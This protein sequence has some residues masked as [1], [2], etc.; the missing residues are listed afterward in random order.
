M[1]QTKVSALSELTSPD[2]AEELLINDGGTSKK[3]TIDN[4]FNQD[5]DVTGTVTTD[6]ADLNGA[7]TI[8]DT[9]AD[10]DFRVESSTNANALVVDGLYGVGIGIG[11]ISSG[12]HLAV[13]GSSTTTYNTTLTH[14]TGDDCALAI[15]NTSDTANNFSGINF[16]DAGGF[17]NSGIFNVNEDHDA[18]GGG[19]LAFLT[20]KDS[21]EADTMTER[22]RIN[23]A[24]NVGIGTG[25]IANESD[26]KKLVISGASGTGA[27]I[28]EFADISN[29][30]DGAIFA[31]GGNLFIVADRDGA[32]ADSSI[33][34][35]VDGSSEKMRIDSSGNVG[36][37]T[38]PSYRLHVETS[39]DG[40]FASL[41]HNTDADNGQGL[42]IRAGADSGEAILS[43]RN[44]ASSTKMIVRADGNVGIGDTDPSEAKLSIDNVAS[45]DIGIKLINAQDTQSLYINSESTSQ[46]AIETYSKYGIICNVDIT[47]GQAGLFT[48]NLAEAGS[49]PLVY[50]RDDHASNTQPALSIKQDGAGYGLYIDQNGDKEG[51]YIDSE[52]TTKNTIW[53]YGKY[54]IQC[55]QDQSG[56]YA[57]YFTRNIDEAGSNPLVTITDDH[58]SNTQPALKIQQ[59]G[60][61]YG[62]SIDQNGDNI[63]LFIDSE[64]TSE[65]GIRV[66]GK[67]A[68][69]VRQD[70]SNGW[71]AE[72]QRNIDEAGT[73]PL[74]TI[75]DDHTSNTAQALKIQ[76]DGAGMG[77]HIDQNG[78]DRALYIDSE[79][80][81]AFA[82]KVHGK[83]SIQC[84]Q[85]LS[86]GYAA[87]FTRNLAEAGSEPLVQIIDDHTSNTQTALKIQQDGAGIGIEIDQNGN[88]KAL[89]IDTE[90]TT[91]WGML[92]S[93]DALTTGNAG[94]FYSNSADTSTRN[95]VRIRNDNA[96]ATGTTTL[97][98]D[99]DSTGLAADFSG[100]GGIRSAGGILFG[101]DTAA[102]NA[103]DDYEEGTWTPRWYGT[104]S[105]ASTGNPPNS[106]GKYTKIGNVVFIS[107]FTQNIVDNESPAIVG[108]VRIDG[109]PFTTASAAKSD[110]ILSVYLLYVSSTSGWIAQTQNNSDDI[111]IFDAES[112]FTEL[113]IGDLGTFSDGTITGYYFTD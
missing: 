95:L 77:L 85:D 69:N 20:R 31:D 38:T 4:I 59:D 68:L 104:T 28:I 57:G 52:S 103:L 43:L 30:I 18:N 99:Q 112:D 32:T 10:V 65:Y 67:Y 25:T 35:R 40:D 24:G 17:A 63:G 62:I 98:V 101:T 90:T 108:D 64:S 53:T 82:V 78:D 113:A 55:V 33:R 109:L 11:A 41:I 26:H 107:L 83:Y 5:I 56:G 92:V 13:G 45:G 48:R 61:G 47:G 44:Q 8:N 9:G 21:T 22:M 87:N 58:T 79:S 66:Q 89:L 36:I 100:T 93:A 2:G 3:I 102:A 97:M 94:Y 106:L 39:I 91:S 27:G 60:A 84:I 12:E 49:N 50:I 14:A 7:V 42:M 51:L 54:G 80:T 16:L 110:T 96:A 74:V 111:H 6:G 46:S 70:I 88:N 19:Y 1:A 76:Q 37:G 73:Y 75:K 86:G 29:N 72:F 81:S 23:G 105:G 15:K 71:G 34:F